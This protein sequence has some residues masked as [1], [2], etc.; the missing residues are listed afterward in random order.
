M[1]IR[2]QK[3]KKHLLEGKSKYESAKLAGYSETTALTHT[4][5][6]DK[7]IG[8]DKVMEKNGLTDS[9]L[10]EKHRKLL[11][12][13]KVIGYLHHYKKAE[14]G[15][16][17]KIAPDEVVS[18]EFIEVPDYQAIAKG[19]E[20]AYKLKGHLKEK[21]EHSGKIEGGT[22]LILVTPKERQENGSR[23]NS[24]SI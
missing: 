1:N 13:V 10:I 7:R 19:L 24:I 6:L 20:L 9:F 21:V 18:N 22:K 11:E 12:A 4:A 23:I 14:K 5:Q 2:Q 17:E 16:I 15:G 8:I 3:Y